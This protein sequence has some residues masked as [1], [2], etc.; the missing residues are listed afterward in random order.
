MR[1]ASVAS[2]S[3][4]RD[5][6][7][8]VRTEVSLPAT[9][10]RGNLLAPNRHGRG[11]IVD[12][13]ATG[14]RLRTD[15]PLDRGEW[16][17]LEFAPAG[18]ERRRFR[19][20]VV[21]LLPRRREARGYEFGLRLASGVGG[22]LGWRLYRLFPYLLGALF[23]LGLANVAYLKSLNV[24]H[25]WYQPLL[26]FYSILISLFILSRL[27]VAAFYRPPADVGHEPTVSVVVAC[28]NEEDS[29]A[30]TLEVIYQS[31][32]PA[33][34]LEVIAVDDGSTDA[35]LAEMRK[36]QA[37]HPDLKVIAFERN[38]GKR[39]GMYAGARA[40]RG[41]ILVYI[42]SDSFVR[43]D[44]IRK[45]VQGF[46]DPEVGAVCGHA[47]VENAR[48]NLLTKM[49]EVRYYVAFRIV[50]AAES[51]FSTVSCCSGC[52]AAYRRDYV[53][54]ILDT[55]VNQRFLGTEATFGDDRALTNWMLRRYRVLYHSE[56]ICTTIVPERYG[57][58]FRQQLRWKKSWIRETLIACTFI[59]RRHPVAAVTYYLGALFPFVGP[60][61]V[62]AALAL[63]L[64]GGA[65]YSLIY[66]Y[67]AL[68]MAWLYCMVHW[69]RYRNGLWVHGIY[70][71][72]LYMAVLAWQTYYALFT[73]RRNHWGT[74]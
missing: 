40:A 18:G 46:A 26:N 5:R 35:T 66:L 62:F 71:T 43:P 51:V 70:F 69:A 30:R 22:G 45:L 73:V 49:Q 1:V 25:F 56:A 9:V 63:P 61:V 15:Y 72:L 4:G 13:S 42:D 48:T 29:I 54:P 41:E 58:F 33:E 21:H 14:A 52:L 65:D 20:Q 31:D 67:G 3:E 8:Q 53:M 6:R 32:Y 11:T 7:K 17:E 57:V 10:R 37:R 34:K 68:L 44:T 16:I 39:H 50:K 74:R 55:W 64:L 19:A 27:L 38:R 12:T 28:M 60:A 59:W 47:D 36:V 24:E 2:A 23:L